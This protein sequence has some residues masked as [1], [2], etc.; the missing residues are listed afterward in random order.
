[1]GLKGSGKTTYLAALWHLV[2]SREVET[3]LMVSGLQPDRE[4]LNRVRDSWLRFQEVERTSSRSPQEVLLQLDDS[5]TRE[6]IDLTLPDLSGEQFRLQWVTRKATRHFAAFAEESRGV[7][8]FVHPTDLVKSHRISMTD[9]VISSPRDNRQASSGEREWS[10][11][12]APTQVQLVE[13]IQF[14]THL[15]S[16]ANHFRIAVIVSAWDLVKDPIPPAAWLE[17]HLPLL[18]Q[19]L[20]ANSDTTPFQIYGVSAL[21][22]DLTKDLAALH[23]ENLPGRRVK[24]VEDARKP[25]SDLTVPIRFLLSINGVTEESGVLASDG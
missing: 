18:S 23:R 21:G 17:S 5:A 10:P 20:A 14:V 1:M 12:S 9:A 16:S 8:L 4:Y 6:R 25:H 11:E 15:R 22:G 19:F 3:S 7:I 13:F 2:E 24:V